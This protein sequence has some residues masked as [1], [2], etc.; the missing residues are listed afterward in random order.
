MSSKPKKK[1]Q[2]RKERVKPKIDVTNE[3]LIKIKVLCDYVFADQYK[4][5]AS[6]PRFEECFGILVKDL[7]IKLQQV[8]MDMCGPKR[9]YITFRRMIKAFLNYKNKNRRNSE[10]FNKFMDLMYNNVLRDDEANVGKQIEGATHYNSKSAE[11]HKAISK[12]SV[13]TDE[14]K[15][16]IKGFQ[17][18]Y[19]DFFKN[20]LFL[21]KEGEKFFISLEI[22]L[23]VE[24]KL[25]TDP[26]EF[27]DANER[28]GITHICGTCN[29]SAITFLGFKCRSGKIL[30]IGKP[31]GKPFI[32]GVIKGQVQSI[33]CEVKDGTLT[34]LD[35]N[36]FE[37]ERVNP[38]VDV[39]P[40]E[41]DENFLRQD[42]PI[43]EEETLE[44]MSNVEDIAKNILQP[45]IK[46]DQFF[47]PKFKDKVR[48]VNYS[49]VCPLVQ[50]FWHKDPNTG[51]T[52]FKVDVK[53]LL[54]E[55]NN[56]FIKQK[57]KRNKMRED[58]SLRGGAGE[59]HKDT[60][61]DKIADYWPGGSTKDTSPAQFILNPT[62]FD[63]LLSKVGDKIS[64]GFGGSKDG[65]NGG[66]GGILSGI[67]SIGSA[68][69]GGKDK[70]EQQESAPQQNDDDGDQLRARRKKGGSGLSGFSGF[71]FTDIEKEFND[72]KNDFL[73][74]FGFGGF[75]GGGGSSSA[76]QRQAEERKRQEL[77]K[78]QEEE[79]KRLNEKK[80]KELTKKAQGNWQKLS[81]NLKK[82]SGIFLLTTIGAVVKALTFL[83]NEEEG[84]PT[85]LTMEQKVRMYQIL[86]QNRDIIMMLAKAHKE[87]LR[88][89]QE[90]ANLVEDQQELERMRQEEEKR[91]AEEKKKLEEERRIREEAQRI[92]QEQAKIAEQQRRREEEERKRQQQIQAE[93][94]AQRKAE[95]QRQLEE[96]KKEEEKKK[97]KE[98]K[99]KRELEEQKRR[100]E[101][102]KR[103]AEEKEKRE[104]EAK[105]KAE[106]EA[107][108]KAE[109]EARKKAEQEA[110]AQEA[111]AEKKVL[112]IDDLPEIEAKLEKIKQL[113]Q[114]NPLQATQLLQYYNELLKDKNA[115]IDALNK[116]QQQK[117]QQEMG[118]DKEEALKKDEEERKKLKEEED[119]KIEE[120]KKEE[121]EKAKAL[122]QVVS[123]KNVEIPKDVQTWRHHKMCNP[124][125]VFTDQN[126]PPVKK[127][128]C[129]VDAYGRWQYPEDITSDD[130]DGWQNLG[131]ARAENIFN[132]KNYQ[133]FY[134]GVQADDIIQGGLGDCYFLSAVAAL[135]KFPKLI[136][137]LFYI[138]EKSAEHCYGC[139]YRVN[140]IWKLV[141]IDDYIPCYGS[142][143]KNFAF[144][145]TNGNEL[146]VILLE[147]AWAKLN[148]NYA[149]TIG[150]EPHEV[151]DVITNAY[152]EKIRNKTANADVIWRQLMNGERN[153]FIMTAGTSGD[154][155]NL[156]LEEKG[157]VPGHAY[158]LLGVKEV[159]TSSGKVKLV[160]LRNPWGN[161][162][163]SGDWCDSSRKW[164]S[165]LKKECDF[166]RAKNDGS[167]WMSYNDYLKY[168]LVAGICHLYEDYVFT[169]LHV[170]KAQTSKGPVITRLECLQNNT[171]AYITGHQKNPR[172][173]LKDGTYQKPV[174]NYL[175]LVDSNNNYVKA[176]W[177]VEMALCVGIDVYLNK[178]TYYLISDINFRYIP[179]QAQHCYN[180]G[181]YSSS[182][183]G[184]FPEKNKDL[185]STFRDA[186]FDYS[187]K[188]LTPQD[189]ANGKL[190][191]SKRNDSEFPFNF[192][193]FDNSNG[194]YDV[195]L[196]DTLQY[197]SG[198]CAEFYLEDNPKEESKSKTIY[199]GG[200]DLFV[201]MP[202]TVNSL[203]SYQLN[204]SARQAS[205]RRGTA[206][207]SSSNNQ[208]SSS[209]PSSSNANNQ[210][211]APT[212]MNDI[213]KEV[214]AEEGEALDQ[215]G[216]L[217]QYI[218]KTNGGYYIG[219][220]NG[221]NRKL[222]MKLCLDGLYETSNPGLSEVPFSI[223]GMTRKIF[224]VKPKEGH[225]GGISFSFAMA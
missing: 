123:I 42:H 25:S 120:K 64:E 152:S 39:K 4:D 107:R 84:K 93:R 117:I 160:H 83:Q 181:C 142:W 72:M 128:L 10:D 179:G 73:N 88:R 101:E 138:K 38:Y 203:Y 118:F 49:E 215:R 34:F 35:P 146:W 209:K 3:E 221:S 6:F 18:E 31:D 174:I 12:L 150:G 172:I 188:N 2:K 131:W 7:N 116:E 19:D 79:R 85:N 81:E 145:S 102:Q 205:G 100:L 154:T 82:S 78:Q 185:R 32:F 14:T 191:Q 70:N 97:K 92:A 202:Y 125:E 54:G 187:R 182:A 112:K 159:Q 9:K 222:N 169:Y 53:G 63:N 48:G 62:N 135:C 113:I 166:D 61:L 180:L 57:E 5:S 129:P 155:Y 219:F 194:N 96:K 50:R 177:N 198:K 213:A 143:G 98:E 66:I 58:E 46:D 184:I 75:F 21:N 27:P 171:H 134:Q 225:R 144:T 8:F 95:L 103:L 86:Q 91:K 204:S 193:L 197:R 207:S 44:K 173:I 220:E 119:K 137:K 26:K 71:G 109:E 60:I 200:Y 189:H 76:A 17:I 55:A 69:L 30:F 133:V 161:G 151:F 28:D 214:F 124:G 223:N 22:N 132:S 190:Y 149:K 208:G 74:N 36:F 33:K 218:H 111:A 165:E 121:E 136:E 90:E 43:Y 175:L 141:I 108:K 178:G 127:S 99:K 106:E 195:T 68:L 104:A 1:I 41:I 176:S 156:D 45:L 206:P 87:A 11:N 115:I 47:N 153:G 94:D 20:D 211:N 170:P 65:K 162:E 23:G 140:G 199:P 217:K 37:V 196:K 52:K 114:Q 164:T 51:K 80:L 148:G 139:Y 168:Y 77:I 126:F 13:I 157:L 122:T 67:G 216:L 147:K 212:N 186:L 89:Q 192:V 167:F 16:V 183:V 56:F 29:D 201:H 24:D 15:E 210:N 40:E 110:A 59:K 158:T 224:L 105:R 163:W 130:L